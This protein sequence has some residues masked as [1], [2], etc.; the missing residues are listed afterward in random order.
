MRNSP[1]YTTASINV[2]NF[3]FLF[4]TF[5]Y[6]YAKNPFN[7]N[8]I[9]LNHLIKSI[10][11]FIISILLSLLSQTILSPYNW[12]KTTCNYPFIT[13]YKLVSKLSTILVSFYLDIVATNNNT[14]TLGDILS[15]FLYLV[16]T[17]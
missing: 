4:Y 8:F 11:T 13:I 15:N 3:T 17:K 5:I 7:L 12:L 16:V 2:N 9:P 14:A 1:I 10:L 6:I